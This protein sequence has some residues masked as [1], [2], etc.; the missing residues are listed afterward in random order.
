MLKKMFFFFR[1][2]DRD[3]SNAFSWP[4][5][6]TSSSDEDNEYTF[7]GPENLKQ[8][9]QRKDEKLIENGNSESIA[10]AT[11]TPTL[12]MPD[13]KI[14]S[15]PLTKPKTKHFSEKTIQITPETPMCPE[16]PP[17]LIG[18]VEI[19]KNEETIDF[20]QV[21]LGG[22]FTPLKC[23]PRQSVAIIIPYRNQP[24]NL[25]VFL[26]NIHP[27]LMKQ[28]LEYRIFVVEQTVGTKFNRGM[29]MNVGYLEAK[30]IKNWDCFIFHDVDLLPMNDG[31]P[32]VCSKNPRHLAV[33]VDK[34]D[35]K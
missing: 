25:A 34:F 32:Y 26:K 21:K 35:Y 15:H 29:L 19:D 33:S 4:S 11:T 13:E 27:F 10:Y 9:M 7:I 1:S 6:S 20:V 31:I 23:Q 30:K 16:T 18:K 2:T 28:Q 12:S 8:P 17:N 3:Q 5:D 24:K 22:Y 14:K